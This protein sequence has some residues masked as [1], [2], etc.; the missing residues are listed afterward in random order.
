VKSLLLFLLAIIVIASP[1]FAE[2][3][4]VFYGTIEVPDDF[5][6]QHTGTLDSFMGTLTRQSDGFT[7]LF[8][9]GGMPGVHRLVAK[10]EGYA[11]FRSHRVGG[12][13]ACTRIERTAKGQELTTLILQDGKV[14]SCLANFR[15]LIGKDSDIAD[16]LL[17]VGTYRPK[18]QEP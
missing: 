18:A 17:I 4:D 3:R 2:T 5:V 13:P 1:A 9:L 14:A 12:L 6:F 15:A 7:I 11:Y 8:D 16:F 10:K